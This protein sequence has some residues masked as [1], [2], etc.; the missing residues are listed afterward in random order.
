MPKFW[1]K[2]S[3]SLLIF[4]CIL[5]VSK[6][7]AQTGS[8][9]TQADNVSPEESL[10]TEEELA[11][12]KD[13]PVIKATSKEGA[14]PIEYVRAG[15]AAGFSIDYLKLIAQNVGLK[16]EFVQGH[17]WADSLKLL[18]QG[19]IDISHN[20][21]Q[22][23]DRSEF[24]DFSPP[25]MQLIPTIFGRKS[26]QRV[27]SAED[28]IDK[29]I[30]VFRGWAS[31]DS[32]K[33][34]YPEL[35]FMETTDP[36]EAFLSIS[37]GEN[38]LFILPLAIGN[39]HLR[40]EF[41]SD[42]E[43]MG[44]LESL[45]L[46]NMA[47]VRLA[48]RNDLPILG[49]ILQKGMLSVSEEQINDLAK[50]WMLPLPLG[51]DIGLT[52][53]E[54]IWLL[55]NPNITVSIDP[56]LIP[57]EFIDENGELSGISGS[58]LKIIG[59]K[60]NVK[61]QH[62][63]NEASNDGLQ[64]I[65][66]KKSDVITAITPSEDRAGFLDFT[67]EYMTLDSM[68]F[69]RLGE[70]VFV[71]LNGLSGRKIAQVRNFQSTRK[72]ARDYPDIDIIE[73][74]T[75][76]EALRLVSRGDA[77]AY[78]GSVPITTYIIATENITNVGTVGTTDYKSSLSIGIRK[79]LPLLSSAV[80]KAF[81][82]ISVK[83]RA[84]INR[85]WMTIDRTS[86]QDYSLVW[87]I[88]GAALAIIL[89]ILAWNYSLRQE[90]TRRKSS[91]ERFKQIAE[92]VDGLFYILHG[93]LKGVDYISPNFESWTGH[94]CEELY[95]DYTLWRRLIHPDDLKYFADA[96]QKAIAGE[97]VTNIPN[98][99]IIPQNTPERWISSQLHPVFDEDGKIRN[100][101][102]FSTDITKQVEA[103]AKLNEINSQFQNAFDYAS[104]GMALVAPD[105]KFLRVNDALCNIL[106]Y[107][108][109]ELLNLTLQEIT[110]ADDREI[111][112]S[113]LTEVLKGK[114]PSFQVEEKQIRSD[115][116]T[117]PVQLNVSM[118]RDDHNN[119]IHFVAQIQNLSELKEREEQL[120]HSQKMDAVGKL[121]GGI[122][123]D[124]NNIL[125]I[126]LGNL[127]ILDGSFKQEEKQRTRLQKAIKSVDRGTN[128]IKKLLSF[129]R[130]TPSASEI[131]LV[132]DSID[133]FYE[134]M[135]KT[136]TVAVNIETELQEEV[137][138]VE[139]DESEFEDAILNLVLNAKD[140]M[141]NGGTLTIR[142]NNVVL[143]EQYCKRNAGSRTGEH[144]KVSVSD[145]G[146]GI[147]SAVIDK[148]LEPFFTTKPLNKGTG[149][150][151]SMVHGFVQRSGGH[152]RIKSKV[153]EGTE[154]SLYI[155]KSLKTLPLNKRSQQDNSVLPQGDEKI[156]I[157]DDEQHLCEVAEKQLSHL[158]YSVY[159]ASDADSAIEILNK[160]KDI[161]LLFS[162]IVMPN[163]QNGYKVATKALKISPSLK[164]LLTSGY[165]QEIE[166]HLDGDIEFDMDKNV[167]QK[168]YNKKQLALAVRRSLDQH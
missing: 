134:L 62:L 126:I 26:E 55:N 146:E 75:I 10:L 54:E 60:L 25:Y 157:V 79:D 73:V 124:F 1:G 80:R 101:I 9:I 67:E 147:E 43:V 93:D 115:G 161:D 150:G 21:I 95:E 42:I 127:E 35:N 57:V 76:Q 162:D 74:A 151:L 7:N 106:D 24:L 49:S 51:S 37:R 84:D 33:I 99:R 97:L 18:E 140:A 104:H 144:V 154:I 120:R 3:A 103:S 68:I 130:N 45:A 137:W 108:M 14:A 15:E 32:Y 148:V 116:S 22:T 56:T 98:Y 110:H 78:V 83:E 94:T 66:D 12:I 141:P 16:I 125:G 112:N 31:T 121:T 53:E 2:F 117:V 44:N 142:T 136:L 64:N 160:N 155:P 63:E 86:E 114:R 71:D 82:G 46:P 38:D 61:F 81:A 17:I 89:L 158:G 111:E 91:E 152:M 70:D 100:I 52:R 109:D 159:T 58:F 102:G 23:D 34:A 145:T 163:H 118:V 19:E 143:D 30:L 85:Q 129:S 28:L 48:S 138:P 59:E 41:I 4:C 39:Y 72:I 29:K 107:D 40:T 165:S 88:G 65:L 20:I 92:T 133:N 6:A 122:A 149:L 5:F 113:L 105:G 168:P 96:I 77:D 131:I 156:L 69:G 27:T 8:D 128:L 36:T 47:D 167:L 139:V 164:I 11:W 50:S 153:N 123:H 132:N 135:A 87:Q 90:V 119:P 13:N 166:E